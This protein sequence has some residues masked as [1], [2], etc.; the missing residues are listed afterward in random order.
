MK[1]KVE[2]EHIKGFSGNWLLWQNPC[3]TSTLA[4]LVSGAEIIPPLETVQR[5]C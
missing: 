3:Q 1:L 4:V 5:N 2:K